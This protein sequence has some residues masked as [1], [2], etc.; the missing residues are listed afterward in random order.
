[1]GAE[2]VAV[3]YAIYVLYVIDSLPHIS[4]IFGV[5]LFFN[6]VFILSFG[7]FDGFTEIVTGLFS[8]INVSG[9]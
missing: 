4:C 9:F 7:G 8:I 6:L 1:M 2:P 5:E 3:L